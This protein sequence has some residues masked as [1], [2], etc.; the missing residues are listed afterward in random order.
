MVRLLSQARHLI[1]LGVGAV[2]AGALLGAN[3]S[4]SEEEPV[5]CCTPPLLLVRTATGGSS[6]VTGTSWAKCF[7]D[8]PS[9][10]QSRLTTMTFGVGTFTLTDIT[11][12]ARTD[13]TGAMDP[14]VVAKAGAT[15]QGDRLATW[16]GTP[17]PSLATTVTATA[18]LLSGG[19]AP[20]PATLKTLFFVDDLAAP[21]ELH[22]G[23]KSATA[24]DGYPTTLETTGRPRVMP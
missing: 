13:C 24:P 8:D 18:V 3:C 4:P 14:S 7:G 1:A 6:D 20:L 11:Y 12:T 21:P 15:T 17:P 10:G 16:D 22:M 2:L 5:P 23:G 19:E 9:P